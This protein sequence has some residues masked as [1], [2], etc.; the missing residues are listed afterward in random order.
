VG[1]ASFL[2][3]FGRIGNKTEEEQQHCNSNGTNNSNGNTNST[4]NLNNKSK[5]SGQECP[6]HT[7][8]ATVTLVGSKSCSAV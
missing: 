5:G 8:L 2:I 1:Q 7:Y 4:T 6:L 3:V